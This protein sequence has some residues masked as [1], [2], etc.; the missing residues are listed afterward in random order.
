MG[1]RCIILRDLGMHWVIETIRHL[2]TLRAFGEDTTISYF[3]LT[4]NNVSS[5][6]LQLLVCMAR[7]HVRCR[8]ELNDT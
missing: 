6:R 1:W 8:V 2:A 3:G 5:R 7:R 4:F